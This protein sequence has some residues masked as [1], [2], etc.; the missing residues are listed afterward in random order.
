MGLKIGIISGGG[1]ARHQD[2]HG[3]QGDRDERGGLI[4]D[5]GGDGTA[6]RRVLGARRATGNWPL[7]ANR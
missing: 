3:R 6:E 7:A 2:K 4:Q 5:A 1:R